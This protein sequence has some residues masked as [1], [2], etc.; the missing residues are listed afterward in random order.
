MIGKS[1]IYFV[2]NKNRADIKKELDEGMRQL[3][4]DDPFFLA[5]LYKQYSSF[6]I[7]PVLTGE[8]QNWVNEHGAIRI[9]VTPDVIVEVDEKTY[10]DLYYEK[11]ERADDAQLQAAISALHK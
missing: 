4:E 1:D 8:E 7:K 5:D 10:L 3:E 11:V 2:I 9:G 6:D